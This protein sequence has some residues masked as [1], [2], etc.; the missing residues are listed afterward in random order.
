VQDHASNSTQGR[1]R[2][3]R[4]M[5]PSHQRQPTDAFEADTVE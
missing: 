4:F 3:S 5:V 1:D 2:S